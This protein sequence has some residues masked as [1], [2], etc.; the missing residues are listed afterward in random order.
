M[1]AFETSPM[2]ND[3][4]L[5]LTKFL[6]KGVG[7]GKGNLPDMLQITLYAGTWMEERPEM[8]AEELQDTYLRLD[9]SLDAFLDHIDKQIGLQNTFIYLMGTGL[10]NPTTTTDERTLTGQFYPDRCTSL[11][12]SHLISRYG[13]AQWVSGYDNYQ[14]FLNHKTIEAYNLKLADV[15]QTALDFVTLFSGIDEVV[16]SHNLIHADFS[17]RIRRLRNG[18]NRQSGGDLLIKLQ[19]GWAVHLSGQD[20]PLPQQRHDIAPGPV[21]LFAPAT[22]KPECI[23][24]P[25]EAT[26]IAPTVARMIRIRAPSGCGQAPLRVR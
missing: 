20:N 23:S 7:L 11:L 21:I 19:P 3:A 17:Q 14:I 16:T 8:Y 2:V 13:Q 24:T 18:Y 22:L 4:V 15:Q 12:N 26:T 25:V 10:T 9:E 6:I 5:E 1:Q